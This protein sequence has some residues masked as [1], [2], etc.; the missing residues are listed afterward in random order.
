MNVIDNINVQN[1]EYSLRGI[2]SKVPFV[3]MVMDPD[4]DS[5]HYMAV[6]EIF[7][8]VIL[9]MMNDENVSDFT[10]TFS[11]SL[12]P[13][14]VGTHILEPLTDQN[15]PNKLW[16]LN[17]FTLI[18]HMTDFETGDGAVDQYML[19]FPGQLSGMI[20]GVLIHYKASGSVIVN[21]EANREEL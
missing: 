7:K 19:N 1:Q 2:V 14:C 5:V 13:I 18:P 17:M 20:S 15:V 9:S 21:I 4:S 16:F 10:V 8:D 12:F 6:P 3:F 11:D